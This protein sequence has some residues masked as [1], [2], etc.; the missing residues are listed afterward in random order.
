MDYKIL[1]KEYHL[2]D[3]EGFRCRFITS[4]TEREVLHAHD[5]QCKA[6]NKRYDRD[7]E[8]GIACFRPSR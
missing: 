3:P 6:Y 8:K 2:D 7:A 1:K 4:D 5:R